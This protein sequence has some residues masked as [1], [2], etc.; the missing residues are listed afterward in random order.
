MAMWTACGRNSCTSFARRRRHERLQAV[1]TELGKRGLRPRL[2]ETRARGD[3]V[4]MAQQAV[5]QGASLVVAAGGDGTI[6]EVAEGLR[7]SK[8][9]LGILPLGTA[10]VLALELGLPRAPAAL[11]ETLIG[12]RIRWLRPGLVTFADG[13]NRLF[14]QMLGMGFDAAVVSALDLGLKRRLGRAA[15]VLQAA[16]ELTRYRFPACVVELDGTRYEAY[17]RVTMFWLRR[18]APIPPACTLPCFNTAGR[19][20]PPSPGSPFLLICCLICRA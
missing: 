7:G 14:V 16:R 15:Y 17:T 19:G 20:P 4:K 3:A 8:T 2:E 12:G 1:L 13:S 10:N 9:Q 6:A 18:H 11:A 5:R